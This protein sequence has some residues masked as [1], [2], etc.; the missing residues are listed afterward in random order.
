MF[1][2]PSRRRFTFETMVFQDNAV[3]TPPLLKLGA[4]TLTVSR[5][6]FDRDG[7]V[8]FADLLALREAFGTE[9]TRFDLDGNGTV[10]FEDFMVLAKHLD[11]SGK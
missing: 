2:N 9:D 7:V 11:Q 3:G 1:N 4:P 8:G 5:L 10:G 6:D